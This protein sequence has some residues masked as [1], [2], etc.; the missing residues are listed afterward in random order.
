MVLQEGGDVKLHILE[1][2]LSDYRDMR[3]LKLTK[4]QAARLWGLSREDCDAILT[5]LM[6]TGHLYRDEQG[7]F[8]L[9]SP[10]RHTTPSVPAR[11][12]RPAHWQDARRSSVA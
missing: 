7:Q 1:R 8:A 12:H 6:A 9:R 10:A 5:V 3:G 4:A 2:V 11:A